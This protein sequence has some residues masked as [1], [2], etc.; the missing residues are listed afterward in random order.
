MNV[1]LTTGRVAL[2]VLL[3]S[4]SLLDSSSAN[5]SERVGALPRYAA[6]IMER[7]TTDLIRRGEDSSQF[8]VE[9]SNRLTVVMRQYLEYK[10]VKD[11]RDVWTVNFL[12]KA[13]PEGGGSYTYFFRH[14]S[15]RE[16]DVWLGE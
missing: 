3:A 16:F 9:I 6:E 7:A 8:T 1:H 15:T 14:P 10:G 13:V 4:L 11:L 5:E 12:P 2:A